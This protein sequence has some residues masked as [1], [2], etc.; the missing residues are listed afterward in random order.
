MGHFLSLFWKE[1]SQDSRL[2]YDKQ[3][4][5]P[6]PPSDKLRGLLAPQGR[7]C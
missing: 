3:H 5:P 1:K 7:L 2:V 4:L 6:P